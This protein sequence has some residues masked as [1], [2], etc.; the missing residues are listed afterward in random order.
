MVNASAPSAVASQASSF[1]VAAASWV[2]RKFSRIAAS[3]ASSFVNH[4]SGP[5]SCQK[6]RTASGFTAAADDV[7]GLVIASPTTSI[8]QGFEL[9][10]T[11]VTA[12]PKSPD[13]GST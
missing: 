4:L 5:A 1:P 13:P 10:E 2:A 8:G 11:P 9:V 7:S 6:A 3:N 12:G